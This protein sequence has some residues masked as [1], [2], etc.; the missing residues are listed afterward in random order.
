MLRKHT[1]DSKRPY[2]I[3]LRKATIKDLELLQF[4]DQQAHV[5]AA[6]PNDEWNWE[7]ELN[8][9]PFWRQFLIAELDTRPI[10]F[11]QIIDPFE[12]ETHYWGNIA[13]NLR[14]ID[15]WIG[16]KSDLGIGYGTI[17]MQLALENCFSNQD[18]TAVLI[19]PLVNNRAAIR[20][21]ERIGFEFVE[22]RWFEEDEC[23]IYQ[24]TR[25]KWS[26]QKTIRRS[27]QDL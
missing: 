20:F 9:T 22:R 2:N 8:R 18:I 10:G 5:I 25:D 1:K 16:R 3:K 7:N 24:I 12:E 21:Y 4:W 11:I 23:L 19:D 17:M 13:P 26:R 6:A 14:A 27:N 15:L